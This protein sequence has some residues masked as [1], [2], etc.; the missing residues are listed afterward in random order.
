ML[1]EVSSPNEPGADSWGEADNAVGYDAFAQ[2]CP[3]YRQT[4]RDLVALARLSRTAR[5][6]PPE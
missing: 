1:V 6:E 5:R 2:R 4:S 3:M